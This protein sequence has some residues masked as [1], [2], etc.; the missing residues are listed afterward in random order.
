MTDEPS[1][2][3]HITERQRDAIWAGLR[4]LQ[5]GLEKT[6]GFHPVSPDDGDLGEIL[7]N[8]GAHQG[9]ISEEIEDFIDNVLSYV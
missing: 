2:R 5:H 6:P 3:L 4:L 7:T 1:N 9:M 8:S